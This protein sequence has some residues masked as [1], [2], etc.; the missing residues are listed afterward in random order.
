MLLD[1]NCHLS[2]GC[3][4]NK[5]ICFLDVVFPCFFNNGIIEVRKHI[6]KVEWLRRGFQANFCTSEPRARS[7][8]AGQNVLA[9]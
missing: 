1:S 4:K 2:P 3:Y 5:H 8:L 7:N 6:S 9:F